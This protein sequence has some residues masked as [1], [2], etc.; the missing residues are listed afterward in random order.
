VSE[1]DSHPPLLLSVD[2]EDWHQLVR[3]R[4]GAANW[5]EGGPALARQTYA[6]LDLL[7]EVGARAT[8]FVLGMAA[9]S[10]PGL[11]E[12]IAARGHELGS[13]GDAHRPIFDQTPEE[14]RADLVAGV[15]AIQAVAG[16]TPRG[17]RAPAFSLT[18]NCAW[19]FDVLAEVGFEYDASMY[20]S[21]RLRHRITPVPQHP[22]SI[23]ID[24]QQSIREFPVAVWN[25]GALK[26]PVGGGT[27]WGVTP[28]PIVLRGLAH[29]GACAG[30]YLH[31]HE[32]DPQTLDAG[33]GAAAKPQQRALAE[34]R[35]AL[36][37]LARRRVPNVLR[38]VAERFDLIA[39]E[40]A[41]E[42]LIRRT[43][44]SSKAL[45]PSG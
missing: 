7:D 16:Q 12:E 13:H 31:P 44:T 11:V 1:R 17:Y 34:A 23:Q 41:Y 18:R 39:Y 42:R 43:D 14:F 27:Y 26:I 29:A 4:V 32:C 33:L 5:S 8:F 21:P 20:D 25:V 36:R 22:Y 9:R 15:E 37:N 28:T 45:S 2:F 10:H 40:D 30:L 3:R 38:A 6:V 19:A 35:S 24:S